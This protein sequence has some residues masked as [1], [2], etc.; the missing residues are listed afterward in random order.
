MSCEFMKFICTL[1]DQQ[2]FLI[3]K[4]VTNIYSL[5]KKYEMNFVT[6]MKANDSI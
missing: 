4:V 6:V 2:T 1:N 3:L 5:K